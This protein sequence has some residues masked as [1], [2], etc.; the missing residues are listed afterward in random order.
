MS[1]TNSFFLGNEKESG[2]MEFGKPI[3][4]LFLL[5]KDTAFTNHGS[6]GT[7]PREVMDERIRLLNLAESHPDRWYRRTLRPLYDEAINEVAEFVGANPNNI[8]FV[9]NATTAINTV[10]K[11]LSLGPED[12]IL[13]NSHSYNACN[14]AI[15]SAVKR[16]GADTLVLDLRFPIRESMETVEQIVEICKRNTGVR[17]AM[18]D[19]ISSPSAIVFPIAAIARELHKLGVLLLVDGAHAPGQLELDLESLGADFYTG[20]LHKWCFA[21]RG[22]AFLWT[23]PA[24]RD[25]IQPLVTSHAYKQDI[26]DQFFVQGTMDHSAYLCLPAALRF[27][28]RLGGRAAITGWTKPLLDWAQQMLCHAFNTPVLP[29]PPGMQA[30]NMRVLRLPEISQYS[31]PS[32]DLAE[33]FMD[34]VCGS[35][36]VVVVI[37]CFSG[38]LWL[39]ISANV[40][41][42]KEDYLQLKEALL[43]Y[44]NN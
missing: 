30:P 19:H 13:S 16:C 18:V 34:D 29:I 6:Y 24:H 2:D 26:T 42:C 39:R 25:K 1:Y 44:I 41:S 12:M 5:E 35:D 14:N 38:H 20:N 31:P 43:K 23:A 40:Y 4:E 36:Q 11:N 9:Q 32:R 15:E 27:Y 28:Q 37:T 17:L 3:R 21:P 33:K 22:S 7:V 10:L 8:V